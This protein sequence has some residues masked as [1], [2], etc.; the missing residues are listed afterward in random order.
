[1]QYQIARL[2][3]IVGKV[4]FSS[5]MNFKNPIDVQ[6]LLDAS[7][8]EIADINKLVSAG[9]RRVGFNDLA[10]FLEV[11]SVLLPCRKVYLG[12]LDSGNCK[13]VAE[14]FDFIE[15]ISELNQALILSSVNAILGRTMEVAVAVNVANDDAQY[16]VLPAGFDDFTAQIARLSGVRLRGINFYCPA[17]GADAK[18][19]KVFRK[20]GVL[21]KMLEMRYKGMEVLSGN[22][23]GK[24]E[25]LVNEGVN[26]IRIG[27]K[28]INN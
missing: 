15:N 4:Q 11:E 27:I 19:K 3:E 28:S 8:M 5:K 14:K 18:Q 7:G 10:Q 25:D 1:M 21:F 24:V 16:G 9:V 22:L 23:V 20:A 26:E 17:F 12:K 6:L 2:Q 13:Q